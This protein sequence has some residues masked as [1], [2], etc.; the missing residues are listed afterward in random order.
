M[1]ERRQHG[2][3]DGWRESEAREQRCGQEPLL[4]GL[5]LK[6]ACMLRRKLPYV[7]L[8]RKAMNGYKTKKKKKKM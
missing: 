3:M 8:Q 4:S 1:L 5:G 6:E 2:Q 7:A